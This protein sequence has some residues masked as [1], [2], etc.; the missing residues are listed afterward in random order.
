MDEG[1]ARFDLP[2]VALKKSP[3]LT[4]ADESRETPSQF[5]VVSAQLSVSRRAWPPPSN[6][7][8]R[9]F[10]HTLL[11][12]GRSLGRYE[13]VEHAGSLIRRQ[14]KCG[15][16]LVC[17]ALITSTSIDF[18]AKNMLIFYNLWTVRELSGE[19]C[20]LLR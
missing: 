4:M 6:V 15:S 14:T 7:L 13:Q 2:T 10:E 17:I 19:G 5:R 20:R 16:S 18:L 12:T 3:R 11:T 8:D 1:S 9:A